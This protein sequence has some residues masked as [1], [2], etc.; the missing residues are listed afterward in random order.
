VKLLV[1][2]KPTVHDWD[3]AFLAIQNYCGAGLESRGNVSS[4]RTNSGRFPMPPPEAIKTNSR[5]FGSR[6][7][8]L[9][10]VP[11]SVSIIRRAIPGTPSRAPFCLLIRKQDE[12]LAQPTALASQH[13]Q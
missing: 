9:Y 6:P 8:R 12:R 1:Q 11:N 10:E 2:Y 4:D 13:R 7:D 3:R 5:V